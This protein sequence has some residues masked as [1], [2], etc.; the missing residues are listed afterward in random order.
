MQFV[1]LWNAIFKPGSTEKRG[2]SFHSKKSILHLSSTRYSKIVKLEIMDQSNPNRTCDSL[3]PDQNFSHTYPSTTNNCSIAYNAITALIAG[4]HA[5]PSLKQIPTT[6][7]CNSRTNRKCYSPS[8][9]ASLADHKEKQ[10]ARVSCKD[11]T[12]YGSNGG[13]MSPEPRSQFYTK[14]LL[15]AELHT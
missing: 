8:I 6:L 5:L 7:K 15:E 4:S 10:S 1:P 3:E 9:L 13:N 12:L 2:L 14:E 11:L